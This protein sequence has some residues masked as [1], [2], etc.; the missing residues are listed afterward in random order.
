MF[1][2]NAQE[3]RCNSKKLW[4]T[5]LM[6]QIFLVPFLWWLNKVQYH[7]SSHNRKREEFPGLIKV[8][9]HAPRHSVQLV[10]KLRRVNY[11]Y[12]I[13]THILTFNNLLWEAEVVEVM[14][15]LGIMQHYSIR[16]QQNS[17]GDFLLSW[18]SFC[19]KVTGSEDEDVHTVYT[20]VIKKP[21]TYTV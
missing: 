10:E 16:F 11:A 20:G 18:L 1:R 14:W 6:S 19:W 17:L 13:H 9:C 5:L 3:Q 7:F 4:N 8:Y 12:N 15:I 2:Q 21:S